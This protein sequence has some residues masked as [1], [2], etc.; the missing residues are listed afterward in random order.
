MT[1]FPELGQEWAEQHTTGHLVSQKNR[2]TQ[3]KPFLALI[4]MVSWCPMNLEWLIWR[5]DLVLGS[6]LYRPEDNIPYRHGD[7]SRLRRMMS[8]IC[9]AS[10][11]CQAL[12]QEL[13]RFVI[14]L[15]PPISRQVPFYRKRLYTLIRLVRFSPS[16]FTSTLA[17]TTGL[18]SFKGQLDAKE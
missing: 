10:N 15:N 4:A 11:M 2:S 18:L 12:S 9:W 1:I 7:E 8:N 14:S 5:P 16:P 17:L 3:W 6:G 13:Y